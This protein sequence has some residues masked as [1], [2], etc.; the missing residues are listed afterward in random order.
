M[1]S[2]IKKHIPFQILI[3]LIS[4]VYFSSFFISHDIWWDSAVF[5]GMGKYIWSLG[6]SGLWEASR[7]LIWPFILGFF[8]KLG[9]NEIIAGKVIV[10]LFSI[11]SVILTYLISYRL[12]DKKTAL[13]SS[14]FLS[15]FPTYFLFANILQTEII[16]SERIIR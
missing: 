1:K 4:I 14:L 15:I 11:G 12:F 2:S 8:W 9:L 16:V 7:P 6:D 10:I 13:L 3:F 5:L